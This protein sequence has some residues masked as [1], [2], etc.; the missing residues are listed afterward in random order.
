MYTDTGSE[1][2]RERMDEDESSVDESDSPSDPLLDELHSK[3]TK[4]LGF[5]DRLEAYA[6]W[7]SAEEI[8]FCQTIGGVHCTKFESIPPLFIVEPG[9]QDVLTQTATEFSLSGKEEFHEHIT[10]LR[11][12]AF[13]RYAHLVS[14]GHGPL[15]QSMV[16]INQEI[17]LWRL[18][19]VQEFRSEASREADRVEFARAKEAERRKVHLSDIPK[20]KDDYFEDFASTRLEKLGIVMDAIKD[21]CINSLASSQ[22]T[23]EDIQSHA[24]RLQD[25]P[26]DKKYFVR[27]IKDLLSTHQFKQDRVVTEQAIR[28]LHYN[29]LRY[30]LNEYRS[31]RE[32][33][34]LLST[35]ITEWRRRWSPDQ[36]EPTPEPPEKSDSATKKGKVK[37]KKKGRQSTK[38][39]LNEAVVKESDS[40]SS[41]R[42]ISSG[43][44]QSKNPSGFFQRG[45][46]HPDGR[47]PNGERKC[48]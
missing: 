14:R 5:V 32:D 28:S 33:L 42:K 10:N 43:K 2:S 8:L 34:A 37:G 38:P 31:R 13:Y 23:W 4:V 16:I 19:P 18:C 24:T 9:V 41:P 6:E 44:K 39:K 7:A 48:K 47:D 35:E 20:G 12:R 1:C 40:D 3:Q 22:E 26:F 17:E 27:A 21:A 15:C 29:I 46:T 30:S 11:N 25:G 45:G 36:P